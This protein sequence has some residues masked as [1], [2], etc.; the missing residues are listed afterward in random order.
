MRPA[1]RLYSGGASVGLVASVLKSFLWRLRN[2]KLHLREWRRR[3][4]LALFPPPRPEPLRLHVGSR[5]ERLEGWLNIDKVA[6]PGVGFV[7]DVTRGLPFCGVASLFAE[8]FL[9]HLPAD[10]ALAFLLEAHRVL[11]PRGHLRLATPNLDW[12]LRAHETAR[13]TIGERSWAARLNR[14]FYGWGH[15]FLWSRPLLAEALAA[16]GFVELDWPRYGESRFPEMRALEQH[17]RYDDS[18]ETPHVLIVEG[19]KGEPQPERLTELLDLLHEE[20]LQH[21]DRG[22]SESYWREAWWKWRW[23]RKGGTAEPPVLDS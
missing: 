19:V 12:V 1:Q 4:S 10:E 20:L 23:P 17:E 13:P 8:H 22:Y 2:G 5:S 14:A 6:F 9:E 15:R 3:A 16:C 11:G 7:A 18:A 21:T